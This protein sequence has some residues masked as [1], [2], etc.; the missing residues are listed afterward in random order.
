MLALTISPTHNAHPIKLLQLRAAIWLHMN[1]Y[2]VAELLVS[3]IFCRVLTL[4]EM[5]SLSLSEFVLPEI[6]RWD[7]IYTSELS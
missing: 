7:T 2:R 1:G 5:A 4:H 6:K 3:Y